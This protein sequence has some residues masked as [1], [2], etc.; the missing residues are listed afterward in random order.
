MD[1]L[2]L[3]KA[4]RLSALKVPGVCTK[5]VAGNEP[6]ASIVV[7]VQGLK[8]MKGALEG[9]RRQGEVLSIWMW[10][11][12]LQVDLEVPLHPP[13]YQKDKQSE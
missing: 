2:Q 8:V 6:K 1:E 12:S 3:Q 10:K 5:A 4:I 13:S 9:K 7:S 11:K